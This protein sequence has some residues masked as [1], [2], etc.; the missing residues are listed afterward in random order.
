MGRLVHRGQ[1]APG[2]PVPRLPHQRRTRRPALIF[3]DVEVEADQVAG[4][5]PVKTQVQ[6]RGA[7]SHRPERGEARPGPARIL[8]VILELEVVVGQAMRRPFP[9]R[10]VD[11]SQ[12]HFF[13][14]RRNNLNDRRHLD[15]SRRIDPGDLPFESVG[16]A[17][18]AHPHPQSFLVVDLNWSHVGRDLPREDAIFIEPGWI[19]V[20]WGGR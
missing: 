4:Q 10:A 11:V 17:L 3:D 9:G 6:C 8:A 16:A 13:Q 14:R 7:I 12:V 2:Q 15:I 20:I 5:R 1:L 19:T 18:Q